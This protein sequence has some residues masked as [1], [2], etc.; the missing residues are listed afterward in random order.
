VAGRLAEELGQLDEAIRSYRAAVAAHRLMDAAGARYRSA[1][2]RALVKS[3]AGETPGVR[4]LPPP[5]RMG[6]AEPAAIRSLSAVELVSLLMVMNLQAPDLPLD[7][8]KVREAERLADEILAL[9]DKAPYDARAQAL[10]V[11]GLYTRAIRVY[12]RGLL[13]RGLLAP[14]HANALL[15]LVGNHP[16]LK[17]PDALAIPDPNEGEKRYAAGLNFYFARRYGDAEKEF[18]SAVENDN[19]DARYYYFL[20]L[21]RLAQGNRDGYEDFDQAARLERVGRPDRATVSK[22][23]ERVQGPL[24]R[25][26]NEVRN[27]PAKD[28][29]R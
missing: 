8:P 17:R 18:L 5:V 2:A 10:A 22:A 4:P 14:A 3:R 1:L 20:G 13:E 9:G 26:L 24:R 28:R 25:A 21:A 7:G 29:A 11:K 27:R 6:K 15:D 23:L 16:V 12:T 19:G